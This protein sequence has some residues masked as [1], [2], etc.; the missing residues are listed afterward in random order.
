MVNMAMTAD[1]KIATAN[2]QVSSFGSRRDQE[3]M[4]E[5]RARADAILAGART[6]DS[7]EVTM[8]PGGARFRALRVRRGL[9]DY[10]IRVIASRSAS[11]DPGAAVFAA[12]FSPIV[13]LTTESAPARR[14]Q[15]LAKLAEVKECGK[16]E[17]D[18]GEAL[19]WLAAVHGV[20]CLLC[21]GGGE[22]ND[23]LFRGGWVDEL[24]LTVCPLIFGGREAPTIAD[25]V[26]VP[27]LAE[28]A[29]FRLSRT[30]H[31]GD[32]TFLTYEAVREGDSA[33]R[34]SNQSKSARRLR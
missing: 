10:P 33:K 22:L 28:A 17:I 2:R 1:G 21:E 4:L 11:L 34:A 25:G 5:L 27:T 32:E 31:A 23:A 30:V 13:I 18:W 9:R 20:K 26:G 14:K 24:H 29:R 12:R 3:H 6:V 16:R 7:A 19:E 15:A 8:G